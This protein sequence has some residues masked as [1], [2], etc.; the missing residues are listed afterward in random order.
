MR[1]LPREEKFYTYFNKQTK[2]IAEASELLVSCVGKGHTVS[3]ETVTKIRDLEKEGD[4][5]IHDVFH[6]LNETFITPI[7][8]EDIHSLASSLDDVLDGIEDAAYR[9]HSYQIHT[10]PPRMVQVAQL[11][12]DCTRSLRNALLAFEKSEA[13]LND[14]IDINR[15]EEEVD[16]LVRLA[17]ADLFA[18]ER[19][20]I[21][22]I[23]LKEVYEILEQ[24]TDSCE[25]VSDVLQ[26]IV[27]KN[28]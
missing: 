24:I 10:L 21:Q 11:L 19:D 26:N 23:K 13:V 2:L 28:S 4:R 7:D 22:L 18:N 15:V 16:D 5:V 14:C 9:I 1:L 12:G 8:P 27:V 25:D 17:V 20:P 6:R 3:P